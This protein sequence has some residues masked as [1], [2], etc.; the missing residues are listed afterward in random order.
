MQN[1]AIFKCFVY[2]HISVCAKHL[3]TMF[4]NF[5]LLAKFAKINAC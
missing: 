4:G 3:G 5:A 2:E 1:L